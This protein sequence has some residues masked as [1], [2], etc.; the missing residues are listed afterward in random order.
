MRFS[1]GGDRENAVSLG[2]M[3]LRS[4]VTTK[5]LHMAAFLPCHLYKMSLI[6][7]GNIQTSLQ[8]NLSVDKESICALRN[9]AVIC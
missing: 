6:L 7:R 8:V 2:L 3:L 4:I 9:D 5:L 1:V